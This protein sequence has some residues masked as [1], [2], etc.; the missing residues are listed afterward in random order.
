MVGRVWNAMNAQS[1]SILGQS[2]RV[3]GNVSGTGKACEN[4]HEQSKGWQLHVHLIG[5]VFHMCVTHIEKSPD[6][7]VDEMVVYTVLEGLNHQTQL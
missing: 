3:K 5:Y 6:D 1:E 7:A 2:R 4:I